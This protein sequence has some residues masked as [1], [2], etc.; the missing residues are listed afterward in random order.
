[1]PYLIIFW[2]RFLDLFSSSEAKFDIFRLFPFVGGKKEGGGYEIGGTIRQRIV[3]SG[4]LKRKK[5]K[6]IGVEDEMLN[7]GIV[8]I[9]TWALSNQKSN[10]FLKLA[11]LSAPF[12]FQNR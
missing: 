2:G 8:R 10:A 6:V 4:L 1:M 5:K 11:Y 12:G 3:A 7:L 9:V